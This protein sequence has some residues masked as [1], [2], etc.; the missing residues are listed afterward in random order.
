[1]RA[2]GKP[3]VAVLGAVLLTVYNL[4]DDNHISAVEW[5]TIAIALAN[6]ILTYLVPLTPEWPW[7]K[8]VV[9][10]VLSALNVLVIV[11]VGGLT[12][13]EILEIVI[14]V[15]TPLGVGIAPAISHNGVGSNP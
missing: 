8:T 12:Q 3:I 2:Y 15:L 7:M 9:N 4:L 6:A 11:I 5:V 14:A 10:V 13:Q 1:M